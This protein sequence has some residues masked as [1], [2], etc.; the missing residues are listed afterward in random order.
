MNSR[1]QPSV[2]DI[3]SQLSL[4]VIPLKFKGKK[5]ILGWPGFK[6]GYPLKRFILGLGNEA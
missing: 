2:S 5:M 1:T 6:K 4:R 3:P